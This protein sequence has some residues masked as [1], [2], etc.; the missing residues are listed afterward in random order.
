MTLYE[1]IMEAHK[2]LGV[3]KEESLLAR[4]ES[5]ALYPEAKQKKFD[6]LKIPEGREEYTIRC[7]MSV[8][9]AAQTNP[10]DPAL[11]PFDVKGILERLR[12]GPTNN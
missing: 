12:H 2:R 3:S 10:Y 11:E 9:I 4:R 6:E 7:L 5:D 1:A 8:F